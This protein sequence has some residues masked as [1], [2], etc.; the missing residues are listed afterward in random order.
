MMNF[1]WRLLYIIDI[2]SWQFFDL[3][4]QHSSLDM[5]SMKKIGHFISLS[6]C[7]PKIPI[8]WIRVFY[9]NRRHKKLPI[10]KAVL[11]NFKSSCPHGNEVPYSFVLSLDIMWCAS[12]H[13]YLHKNCNIN[14]VSHLK[15]MMISIR[16]ELCNIVSI[17][18]SIRTHSKFLKLQIRVWQF[19]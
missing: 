5:V 19:F 6:L 18:F 3:D 16:I 8:F 7:T 12:R 2:C 9:Y 10:I 15:W 13:H 4:H 11:R 1:W 14:E 17:S